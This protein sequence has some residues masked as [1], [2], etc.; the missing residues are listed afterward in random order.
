MT[1]FNILYRHLG[2][3]SHFGG[4][5]VSVLKSKLKESMSRQKASVNSASVTLSLVDGKN[6]WLINNNPPSVYRGHTNTLRSLVI[7]LLVKCLEDNYFLPPASLAQI[8]ELWIRKRIILPKNGVLKNWPVTIR[9]LKTCMIRSLMKLNIIKEE[10]I[11]LIQ[12]A[13][14]VTNVLNRPNIFCPTIEFSHN[15]KSLLV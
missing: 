14:N 15:E 1:I 4:L 9:F 11:S 12:A 2:M 8:N 13:R 10:T 7:I 6:G 3:F 5:P